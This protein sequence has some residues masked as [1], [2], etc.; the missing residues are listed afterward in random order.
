MNVWLN[1]IVS[2]IS[3][4]SLLAL[5]SVTLHGSNFVLLLAGSDPEML[6]RL[7]S[8][9]QQLILHC[10]I[11]LC[12]YLTSFFSLFLGIIRLRDGF[13]D[14]YPVEDY[15]DLFDLAAHQ[16]QG[17]LQSEAAKEHSEMNN[18]IIGRA[19]TASKIFVSVGS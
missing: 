3:A 19:D 9:T 15:L 17:V 10:Y 14:R 6:T 5:L 7:S 12:I 11:C 16:I 13:H 8:S 2:C 1:R 18:I 4:T